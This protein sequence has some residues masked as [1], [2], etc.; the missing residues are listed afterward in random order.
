MT[1][2]LLKGLIAKRPVSPNR[3]EVHPPARP[4]PGA[5]STRW[6][7]WLLDS[8]A[9]RLLEMEIEP[10]PFSLGCKTGNPRVTSAGPDLPASGHPTA[11]GPRPTD[12]NSNTWKTACAFHP[13]P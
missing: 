6:E 13:F 12:S 2:E 5:R 7:R 8:T 1:L 9:G 10:C 4:R 3:E 11:D